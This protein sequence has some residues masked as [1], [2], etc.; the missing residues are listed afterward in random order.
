MSKHPYTLPAGWAED[1]G[2]A[3]RVMREGGLILY[4]TDTIWGIGCDATNA[5]AV[6]KVFALKQRTD[7]KALISLVEND[8][9]LQR[10]VANVPEVAW[11]LIECADKPLTIIYDTPRGLAANLLAED[12]SAALRV[13]QEEFSKQLC[14][15]MRGPVVSTSANVS[16]RPAPKRFGDITDDILSG[17]D[18]VC[19]A[20]RREKGGAPAS[21]ILKLTNDAQVTIIR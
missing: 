9:M 10:F 7:S 16:G 14:R 11:S 1:L 8:A 12:G 15:R 5:E 2:E 3:V 21:S 13:T 19:K 20:R 4:P 6:Q 18:Y 17:V